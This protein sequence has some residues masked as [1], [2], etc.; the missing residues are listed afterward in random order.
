MKQLI[1]IMV[2]VVAILTT[3]CASNQSTYRFID[4]EHLEL[5]AAFD[6]YVD[7]KKDDQ[8]EILN[9]LLTTAEEKYGALNEKARIVVKNNSDDIEATLN[10]LYDFKAKLDIIKNRYYPYTKMEDISV[11]SRIDK[12]YRLLNDTEGILKGISFQDPHKIQGAM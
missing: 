5:T 9:Y 1:S 10:E 8:L 4:W 2:V 11:G 3:S 7:A 12:L 6:N